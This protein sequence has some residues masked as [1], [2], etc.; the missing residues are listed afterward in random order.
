M[1][2]MKQ[3]KRSDKFLWVRWPSCASCALAPLGPGCDQ[4]A[5]TTQ[6]GGCVVTMRFVQIFTLILLL[7]CTI[8]QVCNIRQANDHSGGNHVNGSACCALSINTIPA[9]DEGECCYRCYHSPTCTTWVFEITS[10]E[11]FL[12]DATNDGFFEEV[13]HIAGKIERAA[14]CA[15]PA[16]W[17]EAVTQAYDFYDCDGDYNP[18]HV[19]QD[20][21]DPTQFGTIQ[22][23]TISCIDTFPTAPQSE[24]ANAYDKCRRPTLG[25]NQ[26]FESCRDYALIGEEC[27]V[28]CLPGYYGS[29]M[30]EPVV[31][32]LR[33]C[34]AGSNG[35]GQYQGNEFRDMLAC[36]KVQCASGFE[37]VVPA[38]SLFHC[39]ACPNGTFAGGTYGPTFCENI[40]V[41]ERPVGWCSQPGL[42]YDT[43]DCDED[44]VM[45]HVCQD[46]S[47][48][49]YSFLQFGIIRSQG[50]CNDTFPTDPPPDAPYFCQNG[51]QIVRDYINDNYCDC[52][53]C[54]DEL[55]WNCSSC[56]SGCPSICGASA[57]CGY[58]PD[59]S[60]VQTPPQLRSAC[61]VLFWYCPRPSLSKGYVFLDCPELAMVREPCT[62]G[63]APGYIY[64]PYQSQAGIYGD[65]NF[66]LRC[67]YDAEGAPRNS[68][69]YELGGAFADCFSCKKVQCL[70]G[71]E[72]RTPVAYNDTDCVACPQGKFAGGTYGSAFCENL[73]VCER[74]VGWCSQPGL[75]YD[76]MDCD[77]DGVMDH[78]CQNVSNPTAFLQFGII[79]SQHQCRDTF[80]NDTPPG[81]PYFCQ[82]G[83]EISK[84]RVDNNWCDC[85]NCEDELLWNCSDCAAACPINGYCGGPGSCGAN[86][87]PEV[88]VEPPQL[89]SACDVLFWK[90]PRPSLREGYAFLDCPELALRGEPCTAGCAPG[91]VY[92]PGL[93]RRVMA[94]TYG[95]RSFTL[96]CGHDVEGVP[97]DSFAYELDGAFADWFSCIKVYCPAGF[98]PRTPVAYDDSDCV[99]C[100][101]GKF[102]GGTYG[103][104]FCENL[105]VCER[106]VGWCS[107]PGLRYDTMDCDEDGVMDHVCQNVS[108]PNASFLQ[109]G[110]IRSQDQC[111]DTFPNDT[112]PGA[113]YFCQ[114]GCEISSVQ[115]G[116]NLCDCS[117]CEDELLWN[118]SDCAA[119]C[120]TNEYCSYSPGYCGA[121]RYGGVETPQ[122][123]RST[124]DFLFWK[125]PRP[126]LRE[127]YVFLDCPELALRGEPCT[128]GC[129]PGYVFL[130][131]V[132][133]RRVMADIY[134]DRNFT[135]RCGYDAE[136]APRDSFAYEL[137]GA[138]ADWF[139]CNKVQCLAGFEPRTPVAYND[140]DCVACPQGKF[141]GGTYGSAF[142]ENLTVCERPVGW[143]S[144]PGLRYDTMDCDED[145]VMDHV[146]QNVSKPNASFLQFG[147][148]R[149]QDQCRD[150]FP[151]DTPPGAPYFCQTG[152]EISSVQVGDNLCDCSNC[153]DELLWNC[154]DCAAGCPTNEYCS[155]SPGYCGASRYGGVETPQQLR[156]A[157][158]F[159][160]WKCPRPSL[161]EGYVFLDCP[162][163]ALRGEPCTAGCAPGYV[164]LPSVLTRRVMA[165]IYGDRNFT[166][167]CGYDAEGAPRDSFA[168][169]LDGAFADWFSCNKVQCLAGFEPRTPVAYNDTDCVACPQ[170][171]FAGGTYGSAFCENLTVCERPV[172]WCSQPGLQYDTMDCDEDGMMD[173]VC[174]NVSN[175]TASFLQFGIIRSQ[176]QCKDT[177]PYDTPPGAPYFCQNGCFISKNRVDNNWCDCPNCEDELLWNCSD[178]AAGCPTSGYCEEWGGP[179]YCGASRYPEVGVE[180]PQLRSDCDVLFWKCP[181]PSL[182]E[183]Y[184]FLDCPEFAAEEEPCT[185]GCAPG[186]VYQPYLTR[187]VMAGIEGD[188][189]FT[190]RCRYNIEGFL[191]SFSYEYSGLFKYW[192]S[193]IKVY[194]PAGFEP[195]TPVAYYD[196]DCVACPQ[197]KFAGGA[198][199]S[200]SLFCENLTVCERP[201]GWCEEAA[202]QYSSLDC[203]GDGSLDH[204][205]Q[206]ISYPPQ[207]G[208]ILTYASFSC[209]DTWPNA[210]RSECD[211]GYGI[212]SRPD[213]LMG[214]MME[215][216]NCR[217]LAAEG[218]LCEVGCDNT[219]FPL[220]VM[221]PQDSYVFESRTDFKACEVGG[222][223]TTSWQLYCVPCSTAMRANGD[224]VAEC[225][226]CLPG[227]YGPDGL[228]ATNDVNSILPN[229][230]YACPTPQAGEYALQCGP[231]P[232]DTGAI[233][234]CSDAHRAVGTTNG[235]CG[236]CKS[237]YVG[238]TGAQAGTLVS[239]IEACRA[240]GFGNWTWYNKCPAVEYCNTTT[241][242]CTFYT[243]VSA[244]ESF[245]SVYG[246]YVQV[247]PP[248]PLLYNPKDNELYVKVVE[249]TMLT[250]PVGVSRVMYTFGTPAGHVLRCQSLVQV[251]GP[252][253][254]NT[255]N[256]TG[257]SPCAICPN[258]RWA[259]N[260]GSTTCDLCVPGSTV[261]TC[262]T[263]GCLDRLAVNYNPS[264]TLSLPSSCVYSA[265]LT[266]QATAG[267]VLVRTGASPLG[268]FNVSYRTARQPVL[269]QTTLKFSF[270]PI[271]PEQAVLHFGYETI[272]GN[273]PRR[274]LQ[275]KG[276]TFL[277]PELL[278]PSAAFTISPGNLTLLEPLRVCAAVPSLNVSTTSFIRLFSSA[279]FSNTTGQNISNMREYLPTDRYP[280]NGTVCANIQL[281][282]TY[283]LV[284]ASY[285][286]KDCQVSNWTNLT[287]CSR[288]CG[289]GTYSR[290]REI[291]QPPSSDG[292]QCPVLLQ[293]VACNVAPCPI[294][295]VLSSQFS[296]W[297]TCSAQCLGGSATTSIQQRTRSVL[298]PA[299]GGGLP[300]NQTIETRTCQV[301]SCDGDTLVIVVAQLDDSGSRLTVSF[302]QPVA[303]AA[304]EL[305][306][307]TSFACSRLL[308]F[309]TLSLLNASKCR[310]LG[311]VNT[312]SLQITLG[313]AAQATLQDTLSFLPVLTSLGKSPIPLFP[314]TFK[315]SPP[316]DLSSVAPIAQI[317]GAGVVP[318]CSSVVLDNYASRR[319]AGR[320]WVKVEWRLLTFSASSSAVLGNGSVFRMS[321][322]N[323]QSDRS[324]IF[325]LTVENWLG[326]SG[327]SNFTIKTI[328]SPVPRVTLPTFLNMQV[329]NQLQLIPTLEWDGGCGPAEE[330]FYFEWSYVSE[331]TA[332]TL[333]SQSR[334]AISLVLPRRALVEGV[335][336]IFTLTVTSIYDAQ[337]QTSASAYVVATSPTPV[338]AV[339]AGGS[340]DLPVGLSDFYSLDAS[341]SYDERDSEFASGL[342]ARRRRRSL[343]NTAFPNRWYFSWS[344]YERAAVPQTT[345]ATTVTKEIITKGTATFNTTTTITKVALTI[346]TGFDNL[347]SQTWPPN[348]ATVCA[349]EIDNL[350]SAANTTNSV[351][352]LPLA[353]LDVAKHY[354]FQVEVTRFN[355]S[356]LFEVEIRPRKVSA[357]NT[358][359]GIERVGIAV[360][361]VSDVQ[362]RDAWPSGQALALTGVLTLW[363]KTD[364]AMTSA[365]VTPAAVNDT[366]YQ[367]IWREL[368]GK[369]NLRDRNIVSTPSNS[370]SLIILPDIL[371]P[372][373]TYLFAFSVVPASVDVATFLLDPASVRDALTA[374]LAITVADAPLPGF[375][376]ITPEVG[377]AFLTNFV[378]Q[379]DQ[380]SSQDAAPLFY[381][382]QQLLPTLRLSQASKRTDTGERFLLSDWRDIP[383]TAP[384]R[385][386]PLQADP[387]NRPVPRTTYT[388]SDGSV[389]NVTEVT[390]MASVRTFRGSLAELPVTVYLK[391]PTDPYAVL[392]SLL[393]EWE[394]FNFHRDINGLTENALIMA[395]GLLPLLQ[396][397]QLAAR[398]LPSR[399]QLLLLLFGE[400]RHSYLHRFPHYMHRKLALR[401]TAV[402]A[403]WRG[404]N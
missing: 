188:R 5:F 327:S 14:G 227:Y 17:C 208:T 69:A 195:R 30:N 111:R 277:Q 287:A 13:D 401:T 84:N 104:A 252:C 51:C 261:S 96:S 362:W 246:P 19:C 335:P 103:S 130:P 175:P 53:K 387:W 32:V 165:D 264:A 218:E 210:D 236:N 110:I 341:G 65:R 329:D 376:Y 351:L 229:S 66:T 41:C 233:R 364:T 200:A 88:G 172:G 374:T 221:A 289:G 156:S 265:I 108:K 310:W 281:P 91:F 333:M 187:R 231:G 217:Q 321:A 173:H 336:Y 117:N 43:M 168:Y 397:D 380:W 75:R 209:A 365:N 10:G 93:T 370:L 144:Q 57:Y 319:S 129:A 164:F 360:S 52:S 243:Y 307:G 395:Q 228:T 98:E 312:S 35:I 24:C 306:L 234:S 273:I 49:P 249:G 171:K 206:N 102:A 76:T 222:Y 46:V 143:C 373:E 389:V 309:N 4:C 253:A 166:L 337:A 305:P 157:C 282:G 121:S 356:D 303:P 37:P 297:S 152:C 138:F 107:Q 318:V 215:Y 192:F 77:E 36:D 343:L 394:K 26:M 342:P 223:P 379:C 142:C 90:C 100:P 60:G 80:P 317:T 381:R 190:L 133:T 179:G 145:G 33:A 120:P 155:Y 169:E 398:G 263:R 340:L 198:F 308:T 286:P 238:P 9:A 204:V 174:Q 184:V 159:L 134:G 61:D 268:Q 189:N 95:D 29:F 378:L 44:G 127:G 42:R 242:S 58:N 315:I 304:S 301:P 94:S 22:N 369:L 16:G 12:T 207:F 392:T 202:L 400:A 299:S 386:F 203:D 334:V 205:C 7:P 355:V 393:I 274:R 325:E 106:P 11:C 267:Q 6:R 2:K 241:D 270:I 109:F 112:P 363:N 225:G 132:L 47:N 288:T 81:A 45:D 146:C 350:L 183:G 62:A 68:F 137:D 352:R 402:A 18:E 311:S 361:Q 354:F 186:Y 279:N 320:S 358:G 64:Q 388:R 328:A 122:Q 153:E 160:F 34:G 70:A 331:D 338:T 396:D 182:D 151:N 382:F 240:T 20:L 250:L 332:L 213:G 194:C 92:G 245:G 23:D 177:F 79:R 197:G 239:A 181:R 72:P 3:D 83:C 375:C 87:Y 135:L 216:K 314:I 126:S 214:P 201:A 167:R 295:C 371:E 357:F 284:N 272:D 254:R 50:Q 404:V 128:A 302:S 141:A 97:R 349:T 162:E 148:I 176:D 280:N 276:I 55:F 259:N 39:E 345:S 89:R 324:Y 25:F 161:R 298:I 31:L 339:M 78:V 293:E 260:S 139:S 390:I 232:F 359:A 230:C 269:S 193:C 131:S 384:R 116:D 63:C 149:S 140:T 125:C 38:D 163:L 256:A 383:Y 71:F 119:G 367:Y 21:L 385:L 8:A 283:L 292:V 258:G 101:Q 99:A 1:R 291:A 275:Q 185:A 147:I 199:A 255:F 285:P 124:C 123:L 262:N 323:L 353:S 377:E 372:L 28:K 154:S 251:N 158:D 237:G 178:C 82:T 316:S 220:R 136:G 313:A 74:P 224:G 330:L 114:T 40:T 300:C 326:L 85:P 278:E 27:Y 294:D 150:T 348:S 257:S 191:E 15:R 196:T 219:G 170:G 226:D 105:T 67:G 59:S 399:A 322:T 54:E 235:T 391:D 290:F 346:R 48:P 248:P 86:R 247:V 368:N 211:A 344:C 403:V 366:T 212:C 115:V 266:T 118:C 347:G 113:P 180:P 296:E 271:S 56:G 73:T 244:W